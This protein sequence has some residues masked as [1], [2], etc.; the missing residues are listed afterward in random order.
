MHKITTFISE[1][2]NIPGLNFQFNDEHKQYL[3]QLCRIGVVELFPSCP[4]HALQIRVNISKTA[5]K[6]SMLFEI[7][8][9]ILVR[10]RKNKMV[11]LLMTTKDLFEEHMNK[12]EQLYINIEPIEV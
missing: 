7:S 12:N 8:G 4:W 11:G 3:T 5:F 10:H 9:N 6:G 2:Q 1:R